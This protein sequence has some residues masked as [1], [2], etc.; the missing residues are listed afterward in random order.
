MW[1]TSKGSNIRG[2]ALQQATHPSL[3]THL[4]SATHPTLAACPSLGLTRSQSSQITCISGLSKIQEQ[5]LTQ[6]AKAQQGK[7]DRYQTIHY[8]IECYILCLSMENG[9]ISSISL[10][11]FANK[12]LGSKKKDTSHN[13]LQLSLNEKGMCCQMT[14]QLTSSLCAGNLAPKKAFKSA[15]F[16]PLSC[17]ASSKGTRIEE[18]D[19]TVILKQ[20]Q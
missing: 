7:M 18:M 11:R 4:T 14:A 15:A 8:T 10:T 2:N 1:R 5:S 17:I 19:T 12:M 6:V 9:V 16:N 20:H 13:L 3:V